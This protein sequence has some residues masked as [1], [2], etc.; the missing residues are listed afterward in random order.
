MRQGSNHQALS[1]DLRLPDATQADALRLLEASRS[2]VNALLKDLWFRLDE[3]AE[4]RRGP[5][6]K[7]VAGMT[8]SPDPHGD[9]QFRCEAETAGRILRAQAERKQVFRLIQPILTDSFI[10]PKTEQRPAGKNRKTIK[11]AIAALSKTLAEDEATFVTMQNVVEQA[12]NHFLEQGEFPATYEDMQ[13]ISLLSVGVLTYAGDDGG[14]K[15][16]AYRFAVD[17]E[18]KTATLLFRFPTEGGRWQWRD[19]PVEIALPE[20]V[21]T[22]LAEGTPLAPTLRELIKADGERIAVLDLIVQVKK[23]GLADWKT[24]ERVPGF[25]WG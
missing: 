15:G 7:Q 12:C 21:A 4:E 2:V 8:S 22:R 17:L 10:R 19:T 23:A 18:A 24:I 25:D 3:F 16:Q 20:C 11:E 9:R 5:A 1:Y 6:W 14:T 13:A